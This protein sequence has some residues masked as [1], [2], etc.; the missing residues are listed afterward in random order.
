MEKNS[1][2]TIDFKQVRL[3][4]TSNQLMLSESY[5]RKAECVKSRKDL[6]YAQGVETAIYPYYLDR[7]RATSIGAYT[8]KINRLDKKI[9]AL[10]EENLRLRKIEWQDN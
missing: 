6:I 1:N 2:K 10:K 8:A 4:Y 3:M 7:S 9:E 5:E